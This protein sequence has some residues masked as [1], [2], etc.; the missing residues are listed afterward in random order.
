[1]ALS[2]CTCGSRP[3]CRDR[4]SWSRRLWLSVPASRRSRPRRR[5][6]PCAFLPPGSSCAPLPS[7]PLPGRR[8]RSCA[9]SA[10][11]PRLP[12]PDR[13][14]PR[15]PPRARGRVVVP[16]EPPRSAERFPRLGAGRLGRRP[17]RPEP[18]RRAPR[19]EADRGS[20]RAR[21]TV[22]AS[23]RCGSRQA[24]RRDAAR[25]RLLRPVRVHPAGSVLRRVRARDERVRP[26]DR[27][28][29][30]RRGDPR[31]RA[32][33][34]CSA[35]PSRTATSGSRTTSRGNSNA[36]R[37][38]A[39]RSTSSRSCGSAGDRRRLRLPD[40][41]TRLALQAAAGQRSRGAREVDQQDLPRQ[42]R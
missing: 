1:M 14:R 2:L 38:W 9:S 4:S 35:R 13:A 25:T 3:D 36:S 17:A 27:L 11:S 32:G 12:V 19:R 28:A 7:T 40:A 15:L 20:A 41:E 29:E 23:W 26:H 31:H 42:P 30:R 16:T 39:P 8:H 6:L 18:D 21:R 34:N 5:S 10:D 37:R 24:G 22:A 33:H